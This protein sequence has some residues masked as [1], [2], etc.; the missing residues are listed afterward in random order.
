LAESFST[1]LDR[2]PAASG[3]ARERT[4]PAPAPLAIQPFAADLHLQ[5]EEVAP[6]EVIDESQIR[7]TS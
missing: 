3:A 5:P 1:G 2:T 4:G 6:D 7:C